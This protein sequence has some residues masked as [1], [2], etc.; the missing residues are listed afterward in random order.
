MALETATDDA[1]YLSDILAEVYAGNVGEPGP[2][3]IIRED[4][5]SLIESLYSTKKVRKKTMRV[6]ISS[7]QQKLKS[8]EIEDIEHISSEL[9]IADILTKKRSFNPHFASVLR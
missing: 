3:L 1:V 5:K 2:P 6:V 4:S 9:Q 8:R 7:L